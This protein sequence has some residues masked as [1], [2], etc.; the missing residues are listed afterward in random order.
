MVFNPL[1]SCK[2]CIWQLVPDE[3]WVFSKLVLQNDKVWFMVIY[4][5]NWGK[6]S[7]RIICFDFVKK[8]CLTWC[9]LVTSANHIG[10]SFYEFTSIFELLKVCW[11]V[12]M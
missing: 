7:V 10:L 11:G 4:F 9:V 5:K 1:S 12:F 6:C 8:G 3:G 2:L